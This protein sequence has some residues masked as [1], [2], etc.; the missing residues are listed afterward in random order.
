MVASKSETTFLIFHN[1]K[2]P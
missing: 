2:T 1:F